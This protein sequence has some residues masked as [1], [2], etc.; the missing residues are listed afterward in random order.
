MTMRFDLRPALR[1]WIRLFG[2]EDGWI[3]PAVGLLGSPTRRQC[4]TAGELH[5][6]RARRPDSDSGRGLKPVRRFRT[7]HPR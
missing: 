1:A 6:I 4:Q 3:T 7:V 5:S 2:Q